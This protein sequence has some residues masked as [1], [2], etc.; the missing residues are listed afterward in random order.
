MTI[1]FSLVLWMAAN[2]APAPCPAAN[3]AAGAALCKC[4]YPSVEGAF[5]DSRTVF[6]GVVL[7]VRD[8]P[9]AVPAEPPR[10]DSAGNTIFT[11]NGSWEQLVTF[12]VTRGWKGAQ[13]G[14]TVTVKDV[15]VCGVG[16][17]T[18]EEYLVYAY[19]NEE[20][21]DGGLF[22]S[23]CQRTRIINPSDGAHDFRLPPPGEDMR[24]LDSI[25]RTRRP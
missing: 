22:T 11:G 12:R 19:P 3:G 15:F 5:D 4:G 6:T 17:R 20:I 24:M 10:E 21:G 25:I 13:A 14:D 18:G 23:P 8:V 1:L 9:R 16:F 7:E 2:A